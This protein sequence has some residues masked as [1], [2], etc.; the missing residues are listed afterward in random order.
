MAPAHSSSPRNPMQPSSRWLTAAAVLCFGIALLHVAIIFMGPEGY[1][2][3]GAPPELAAALREAKADLLSIT[4]ARAITFDD[5][6][7]GHG[8]PAGRVVGAPVA[9]TDWFPTL[10][11]FV[12][13]T[14]DPRDAVGL[15]AIHHRRHRAPGD[16]THPARWRDQRT[17]QLGFTGAQ[18]GA[19]RQGLH[20]G[21]AGELAVPLPFQRVPAKAQTHEVALQLRQRQVFLTG[22]AAQVLTLLLAAHAFVEHRHEDDEHR[23]PDARG[24]PGVHLVVQL[25][26]QGIVGRQDVRDTG[27]GG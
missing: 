20:D 21:V 1:T 23:Q 4:R 3:F 18:P 16:V 14:V 24:G 6:S 9:N 10:L 25:F 17:E 8:L 2:Y 15:D 13:F 5:V 27:G 26:A 11:E 7:N 12:G 19:F 22:Q